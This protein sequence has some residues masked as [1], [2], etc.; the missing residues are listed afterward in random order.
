MPYLGGTYASFGGTFARAREFD[1]RQIDENFLISRI[2][3]GD[4]ELEIF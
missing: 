2:R 1:L 3:V 4:A